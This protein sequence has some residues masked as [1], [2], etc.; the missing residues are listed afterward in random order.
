MMSKR[1]DEGVFEIEIEI[2]SSSSIA[3][4]HAQQYLSTV[5]WA[6]IMAGGSFVLGLACAVLC[7]LGSSCAAF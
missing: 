1:V 7:K 6:G 5:I 4:R 2:N 3:G